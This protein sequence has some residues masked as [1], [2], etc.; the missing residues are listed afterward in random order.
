M[1]VMG[2][3]E[4]KSMDAVWNFW[5]SML[6]VIGLAVLPQ[7]PLPSLLHAQTLFFLLQS[8]SVGFAYAN[9]LPTGPVADFHPVG[10][11]SSWLCCP[12]SWPPPERCSWPVSPAP[13][14]GYI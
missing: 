10:Q 6:G 3:M 1:Q 13:G 7:V 2:F 12:G 14:D 5:Q 11:H 9:S 4:S 8:P